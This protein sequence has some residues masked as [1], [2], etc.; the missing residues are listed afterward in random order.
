VTNRTQQLENLHALQASTW[1]ETMRDPSP[2]DQAAFVAWLKESPRNVRDFLLMLSLDRALDDLD[3]EHRHNIDALVAGVDRRVTPISRRTIPAEIMSPRHWRRKWVAVA[4]SALLALAGGWLIW[5]PS[6]SDWR[7]FTTATGEQR[8]FELE[9]GSVINLNTHSRVV[10][11][12]EHDARDVRLLEG[13]ALFN[14]HHDSAR[15]FR[16]YT[17]DAVVQAVGTQF[18]VY[19][20]AQDTVVSVIAG[21]VS[22]AAEPEGARPDFSVLSP[23]RPT[24]PSIATTLRTASVHTVG[25]SEEAQIS[26][27]GSVSVRSLPDVTEAVA[28]RDR[29]LIFRQQT[30]D[31]IVQE[32]NRYSRR[33][34][35]L[36]GADVENRVYTGVFDVDDTESL[37]QVLAHDVDLIVDESDAGIVIRHR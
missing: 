34:I 27:A 14:V 29:R 18:N 17:Q 15:P 21:R 10:I 5:G 12:F 25:P 1:V 8:A 7:T 28:W 33:Q 35:Q 20:R 32:F 37:E 22:V 16:V 19:K 6:A 26:S 3:A 4:A 36:K 24:A 23:L 2:M 13:E 31:H 11:R 30:L 9:D